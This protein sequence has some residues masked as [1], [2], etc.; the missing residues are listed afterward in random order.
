MKRSV[1]MT[2]DRGALGAVRRVTT[3]LVRDFRDD[4]VLGLSAELA[5]VAAYYN[6]RWIVRYALVARRLGGRR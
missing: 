4:D 5:I 6:L 1:A 3:G 2:L